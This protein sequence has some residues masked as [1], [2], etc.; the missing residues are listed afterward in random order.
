[1]TPRD[2]TFTPAVELGRLYRRRIVSPLEVMQAF[3]DRIDAVNPRVNAVVTLARESALEEARKATARLKSS[4][5]DAV[6]PPCFRR[7]Q[8]SSGSARGANT[9]P[10]LF[11]V[12]RD[13]G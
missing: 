12:A 10:P 1:M 4:A 11:A 9:F 8:R 7:R 5:S 6:K 2:L 3:L 13:T